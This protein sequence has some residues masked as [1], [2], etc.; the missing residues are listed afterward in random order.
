MLNGIQLRTRTAGVEYHVY[1]QVYNYCIQYKYAAAYCS[2]LNR[3]MANYLTS[4]QNI[5][6]NNHLQLI[7]FLTYMDS[8]MVN[9]RL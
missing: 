5:L 4:I 9:F 8:W 6:N 1:V 7:Q 3:A 2:H